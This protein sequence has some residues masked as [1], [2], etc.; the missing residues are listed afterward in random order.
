[1]TK[2]DNL[3]LPRCFR[4]LIKANGIETIEDLI[5]W[6]RNYYKNI[7]PEWPDLF[8]RRKQDE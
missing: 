5:E 1:M 7:S 4:E 6:H 3:K 2:I 8:D